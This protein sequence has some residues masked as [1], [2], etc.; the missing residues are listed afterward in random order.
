MTK[1]NDYY[2]QLCAELHE[3]C[4]KI[5]PNHPA[6]SEESNTELLDKISRLTDS[7]AK[8][9][10]YIALGQDIITHIISHY[11]DITPQVHRDLLWFFGGDCLHYLGDNELQRYQA[12]EELYYEQC[13]E[14]PEVSYRNIRAQQFGLH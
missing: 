2:F 1:R 8:S 6:H 12:I 5:L 13:V 4:A 7:F 9:N 3:H 10:D 14:T 11:P